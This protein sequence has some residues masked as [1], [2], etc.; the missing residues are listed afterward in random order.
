LGITPQLIDQSL[1]GAFGQAQVSTIHASLNQYHVV[2]EAAR[3][4]RKAL[5]DE[6]DLRPSLRRKHRSPGR[7]RGKQQIRLLLFWSITT[8]SFSRSY[9]VFQSGTWSPLEQ[10]TIAIESC[11]RGWR[12]L[13]LSLVAL[14]AP[15]EISRKSLID[16]IVLVVMALVCGLHRV[17]R[18]V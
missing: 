2:M 13:E 1:Y 18:L 3:N 9:G 16:Q 15:P 5:G 8:D 6:I 10:A 12:C 14:L 11:S 4:M 7:L 17:G